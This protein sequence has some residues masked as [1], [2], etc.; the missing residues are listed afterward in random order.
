MLKYLQTLHHFNSMYYYLLY[1]EKIHRKSDDFN[2]DI[3]FFYRIV[4]NM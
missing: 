3:V 4:C 2:E 1:Q